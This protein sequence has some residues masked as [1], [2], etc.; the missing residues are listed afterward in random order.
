MRIAMLVLCVSSL[1]SCGIEADDG[2]AGPVA[3]SRQG[4]TVPRAPATL[5]ASDY[6]RVLVPTSARSAFVVLT[7]DPTDATSF[8][9]WGYDVRGAQVLFFFRGSQR[10]LGRFQ[11]KVAGDINACVGFD[12]GFS[13]G[14]AGQLSKKPNP[15]NPG[16]DWTP[17]S[18]QALG[19]ATLLHDGINSF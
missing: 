10:E 17:A 6:T 14:L 3:T 9:A 12:P 15:P 19:A 2:E 7:V 18:T 8:L 13:W 11:T 16:N 1:V 4:L 5:T